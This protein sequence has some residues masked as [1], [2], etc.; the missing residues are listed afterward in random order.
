MFIVADLVSLKSNWQRLLTLLFPR[1][2]TYTRTTVRGLLE[3]YFERDAA[4]H[5]SVKPKVIEYDQEI[6]Q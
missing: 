2:G 4:K 1:F 6:P 5:L 3:F